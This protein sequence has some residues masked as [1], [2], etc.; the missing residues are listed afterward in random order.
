[1]LHSIECSTFSGCY[2]Y[3]QLDSLD[4]I[5]AHSGALVVELSVN[6]SEEIASQ[7]S[8]VSQPST[9]SQPSIVSQH[10]IVCR[11]GLNAKRY[12][13]RL[14]SGQATLWSW[15]VDCDEVSTWF[16]GDRYAETRDDVYTVWVCV[17]VCFLKC[18]IKNVET[19]SVGTS[20]VC[21]V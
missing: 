3:L 11:R 16:C 2:A 5:R 17:C 6:H 4:T 13:K 14:W 18:H 10:S 21:S 7:P 19:S 15:E 1:M 12:G 9:V 20:F 8:I